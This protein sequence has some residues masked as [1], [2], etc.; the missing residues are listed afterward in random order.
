MPKNI[1]SIGQSLNFLLKKKIARGKT[2]FWASNN[3]K[4]LLFSSH[5]LSWSNHDHK[6]CWQFSYTNQ[7]CQK[8]FMTWWSKSQFSLLKENCQRENPLLS[9]Q[10]HKKSVFFKSPFKLKQYGH[11]TCWR[12]LY[13]NQ[14][15]QK[16]SLQLV[17]VRVFY[18]KIKWPE[19]E[20]S[21]GQSTT[22]EICL[23][24]QVIF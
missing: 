14:K 21:F 5:L 6:T 18:F 4:I 8:I 16:T 11:K 17:K 10:Q 23:F 9:E 24:F 13:T 19:G 2:I 12:F 7:K 20:P 15:C 22:E 1:H 3:I